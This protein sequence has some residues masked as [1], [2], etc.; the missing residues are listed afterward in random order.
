M[1][2]SSSVINAACGGSLDVD[3]LD[4]D[5]FESPALG[6]QM[7]CVCVCVGVCVCV[8]DEQGDLMTCDPDPA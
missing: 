7:V 4:H 2:T 5:G 6:G 3:L 1:A 8:Y